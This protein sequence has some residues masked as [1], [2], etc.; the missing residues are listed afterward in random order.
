MRKIITFITFILLG[1]LAFSQNTS[2]LVVKDFVLK[3]NEIIDLEQI[4]KF[5]RTDL[6]N[7]PICRIKV[8]AVGF[9][10]GVLQKFV[11]VPNGIE[12]THMVYKDGMWYLHVSSNKSGEI[13]I[14]YMGDFTFRLPYQLEPG[15]VY[16]LSVG[17]ETATLVIRTIPTNAEIYIDNEKAGVGEAIKAVSIGA[18]HRYRVSCDDY[19]TKEGVVQFSKREEKSINVELE[20]NFGYITIKTDPMGADVYVDDVKVGTTPYQMKKIT[21]GSHVVEL[22]R[23]GF[24]SYADIVN[25]VKGEVNRQLENVT[26]AAMRLAYGTLYVA[27]TPDA[28]DITVDGEYMGRTPQTLE[29]VVGNHIVVVT[30][31]GTTPATKTVTVNEGMTTNVN[32][33]LES[34]R[35]ITISTNGTGDKVYVDGTYIGES[36]LKTMLGYGNHEIEARRGE[37]TSKKTISVEKSGGISAV[38]LDISNNLN[39][40]VKGYTF[41][42]IKVDGGTMKWKWYS[43]D[44]EITCESFYIGKY[45]VTVD[46]YNA[47]MDKDFK[48]GNYPFNY[49]S[50]QGCQLFISKLNALTGKN[51][52]LPTYAEWTYAARG[53]TKSKGYKYSGSDNLDEV[54]CHYGNSNGIQ[55]VGTK[56]PN[57]LGIYDMTG[58][59]AEWC[60]TNGGKEDPGFFGRACAGGSYSASMT[61]YDLTEYH[62]DWLYPYYSSENKYCGFRLVLDVKDKSNS[63]NGL[64]EVTSI[65]DG[66]TVTINGK[67]LG[68][69]PLIIDTLA[70]SY[71][72]S[73]SHYGYTD[74]TET[75]KIKSGWKETT[76]I[77]LER[78]KDQKVTDENGVFSISEDVKVRFA[79]GN[80]QYMASTNTWRFAEHPWDVI[81]KGNEKKSDTYNGWIDLFGWGTGDEPTKVYNYNSYGKQFGPFIDWGKNTISNGEGKKWFTLTMNEW[82]YLLDYR[83]TACGIN[84]VVATVNK[85]PG[86]IILPDDWDVAYYKFGKPNSFSGTKVS[87]SDWINIFETHGAVFLPA[88]AGCLDMKNRK[89]EVV[90][91]GKALGYYWSSTYKNSR[92]AYSA[93][94]YVKDEIYDEDGISSDFW[95]NRYIGC[96]V[97]LVTLAE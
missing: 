34:G 58:N 57:E 68:K 55:P 33:Y 26:L 61:G 71:T 16:E 64:M 9:E 96:S 65:P 72:L 4:P 88:T 14:K 92:Q 87:Q 62:Q 24:E 78:V 79:K 28:A 74:I 75:I 18:E 8:K 52:R 31:Q 69:T 17:M 15:K 42:M 70:G 76:V 29:L 38:N 41:E 23:T 66:A 51:F 82:H 47:V 30:K 35:E 83:K 25:I 86:L 22:R 56:K 77:P 67:V 39:I 6:D 5:N 46:L 12:I 40:T 93:S 7:N 89:N 36:P 54:A 37:N 11:F 10:E 60:Q 97:R 27:S 90:D 63:A 80:L 19:Y 49:F 1:F 84:Y 73:L 94:F 2:P 44:K 81:G 85:V 20:S 59:I 91:S 95:N 32:L 3:S 53:G 13:N 50:W 43:T 45:E 21:L 48:N